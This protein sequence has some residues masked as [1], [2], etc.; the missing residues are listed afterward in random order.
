MQEPRSS[1]HDD[2]DPAFEAGLRMLIDGGMFQGTRRDKE[3][4]DQPFPFN[5]HVLGAVLP[6]HEQTG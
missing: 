4:S 2:A 6:T 5:A 1:L 3:L